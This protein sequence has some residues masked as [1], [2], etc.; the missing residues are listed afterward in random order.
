[1]NIGFTISSP[2]KN[3]N[4]NKPGIVYVIR[5]ARKGV[6]GFRYRKFGELC[7]TWPVFELNLMWGAEAESGIDYMT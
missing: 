7:V 2:R 4:D 6:F 1:M 5:T 3:R